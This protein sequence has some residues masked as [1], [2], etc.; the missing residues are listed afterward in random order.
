MVERKE[1]AVRAC[2]QS[3]FR[4]RADKG[5][6]CIGDHIAIGRIPV[7]S[8][9]IDGHRSS[10][11]CFEQREYVR[12]RVGVHCSTQKFDNR[13]AAGTV[14]LKRKAFGFCRS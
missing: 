14:D 10:P 12:L 2:R 13:L 5:D 9:G 3:F 6:A 1:R 11:R 8:T 4:S 7:Y